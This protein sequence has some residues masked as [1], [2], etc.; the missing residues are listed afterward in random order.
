MN[1][2]TTVILALICAAVF[3]YLLLV[4]KPWE[5]EVQPEKPTADGKPL[6]DPKPEGIDR[7]E[8]ARPD[9]PALVF[10]R[11]GEDEWNLE[12]PIQAPA[13]KFEVDALRDAITGIHYVKEYA[14]GAS[15]RPGEKVTGLDRPVATVKML[16]GDKVALEVR[17]GS[18]VPTGT[19]NYLHTAGSDTI[20]VS[21]KDLK[22]QL[23]KR[24]DRYRDRRVM[25]FDLKDVK[26]VQVEGVR[27][28]ELVRNEDKS[29]VLETPLRG[30]ADKAKAEGVARAL[31]NLY[32]DKFKDDEPISDKPYG[33][34]A[35]QLKV[36][37]QTEKE[38]PPKA[39]PGDPDTRPADT[40][41]SMESKTHVLMV[42]GAT[43]TKGETFFARIGTAPWVF[44]IRSD[45]YKNLTPTP[46][47]LRDKTI[48]KVD[49]A[50]VKKV[51]AHTPGG[52]MVLTKGGGGKWLFQD[53]TE[54]D[55][56]LVDDLIKAVR[57]LKASKYVI[58]SKTSLVTLDW[59]HPRAR[60]ALT[61]EGELNP[62]AVLV[63]PA[64]A[65]G[66]MV[67]VRNAAEEGVATVH[68]DAVAQ[69]IQPPVSYRDRSVMQFKKDRVTRIDITR[70][71][72]PIVRLAK[73]RNQWLL[74]EPVQA[75]A[76]RE[77]VRNLVQDLS[78]LSAKRVAGI[79]DK[80][81]FGLDKPQVSLAVWLEPVAALPGAKVVGEKK[82]TAKPV[83]TQPAATKPAAE[84]QAD[85]ERDIEGLQQMLE[86]QK[87]NPQAKPEV[88][89]MLKDQLAKKM[90]ATQPAATQPA[91]EGPQ[92]D[93]R[94]PEAASRHRKPPGD[95]DGEG[96][97]GQEAGRHTA[98]CHAAGCHTAG[99]HAAGGHATRRREPGG[100][101][102][103]YRGPQTDTR[104]PKDQS[105]GQARGYED[106]RGPVGQE[107]GRHA[108]RHD[109]HRRQPAG[110]SHQTPADRAPL[111]PDAK[112]RKD[113]C[114]DGGWG[115][116]LSAR[117]Q[118]LRRCHR[119]D[120]R[121][122]D[123]PVRDR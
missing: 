35:P 46:S 58:D 108:A 41:P 117:G 2:K 21:K 60:V 16:A 102:A 72:A 70:Q 86:F 122:S 93:A 116:D 89:R 111:G 47:E 22:A 118:G 59:D 95:G 66:R 37:V 113:L 40:Q 79:G 120:A 119:R 10:T 121:P 77:A 69:L 12:A 1:T 19:G 105:A 48:A 87:T 6:L 52:E 14:K 110:G 68:E 75:K 39:K 65:S 8:L 49:T 5:P 57:D 56:A 82:E 30:R 50:K 92:A 115:Y 96:P 43:D 63:G 42:G 91:A 29:W 28:F 101:R 106:A 112:G 45:T 94:I 44:S 11:A 114:R 17:I 97:P 18:R 78:S 7:I 61:L 109:A 27:N 13:S 54:A 73:K 38:I 24:M 36:T 34:D 88:T 67:Y 20:Y 15:G 33:L 51:S 25:K 9:G 64:S 104:V 76:G 4:E 123:H 26:R 84:S 71:D 3:A 62:V 81:R 74:T 100:H 107:A 32:V 85:I 98:G 99:C 103:R 31:S 83:T 23:N 55:A 90:A 80:S 53:Q